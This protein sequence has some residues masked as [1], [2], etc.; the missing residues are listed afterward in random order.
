MSLCVEGSREDF[1]N[2]A[3]TKQGSQT[4]GIGYHFHSVYIF[5][6]RGERT[7]WVQRAHHRENSF[8]MRYW[9]I[10]P[11][12]GGLNRQRRQRFTTQATEKANCKEKRAKL[13]YTE[14][15]NFS[16]LKH[17]TKSVQRQAMDCEK[18]FAMLSIWPRSHSYPWFLTIKTNKKKAENPM[19]K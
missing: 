11:K 17:V 10:M 6:G 18:I 9:A 13:V 14:M 3:G 8:R 7:N 16:L 15:N 5:W 19:E 1:L 2:C 4:Q 12:F